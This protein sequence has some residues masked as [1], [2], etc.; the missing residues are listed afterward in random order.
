MSPVYPYS[1]CKDET[2]QFTV[3]IPFSFKRQQ[4][5]INNNIMAKLQFF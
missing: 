5:P 2:Y 4:H 1:P 3:K